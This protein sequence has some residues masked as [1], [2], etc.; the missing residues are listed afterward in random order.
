[1]EREGF[2]PK[3][4]LTQIPRITMTGREILHIEQHQ[5]LV[6]YQEDSIALRTAIGTLRIEGE[7]M[8]FKRYTASDA[9]IAGKIIGMTLQEGASK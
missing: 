2:F 8:G 6:A 1:M 4:L 7:G 9:V 5:G 3:E